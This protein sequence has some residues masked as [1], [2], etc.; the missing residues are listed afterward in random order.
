MF[1]AE[2][3][4][5][6]KDIIKISIKDKLIIQFKLFIR[7]IGIFKTYQFKIISDPV[8]IEDIDG[9]N[10]FKYDVK[11]LRAFYHVFYMRIFKKKIDK[12]C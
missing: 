2:D 5:K 3:Y 4:F 8:Q 6:N 11:P 1:F 12:L 7:W 9:E 10:A